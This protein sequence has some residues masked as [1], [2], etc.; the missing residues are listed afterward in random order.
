MSQKKQYFVEILK[1]RTRKALI[2]FSKCGIVIEEFKPQKGL[3]FDTFKVF[4][5]YEQMQD[6]TMSAKETISH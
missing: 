4:A 1:T 6:F 3:N 2:K 5:T